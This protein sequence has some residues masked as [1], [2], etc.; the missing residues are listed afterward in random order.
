MPEPIVASR[1]RLLRFT[2]VGGYLL[3]VCAF[4]AFGAIWSEPLANLLAASGLVGGLLAHA[5]AWRRDRPNGVLAVLLLLGLALLLPCIPTRLRS[6][7][8]L[9]HFIA[10]GTTFSSSL[11]RH[12]ARAASLNFAVCM[13]LD[14]ND[15]GRRVRESCANLLQDLLRVTGGWDLNWGPTASGIDILVAVLALSAT[16]PG[17]NVLRHLAGALLTHVLGVAVA[18]L[19]FSLGLPPFAHLLSL[20]LT[21]ALYWSL[22]AGQ[23]LRPE[24]TEVPS[25]HPRWIP[26]ASSLSAVTAGLLIGACDFAQGNAASVSVPPVRVL[27]HAVGIDMRVPTRETLGPKSAGMFGLLPSFFASSGAHVD[28]GDV[29]SKQLSNYDLVVIANPRESFDPGVVVGI[30]AFVHQGGGLLLMGDHTGMESIR[31]PLNEIC[32]AW[33]IELNF[34][35]ARQL[36]GGWGSSLSTSRHPVIGSGLR[37]LELQIWTGASLDLGCDAT[38]IVC[39]MLGFSDPGDLRSAE[40]GYLGDLKY[41]RNERLGDLVLV[42]AAEP[43]L[44]RVLVFGDTSTWQNTA[45]TYSSRFAARCIAWLGGGACDRA[46]PAALDWLWSASIVLLLAAVLLAL[47]WPRSFL[48][49]GLSAGFLSVVG[50]MAA[51]N[52]VEALGSHIQ[53]GAVAGVPLEGRHALVDLS[54]STTVDLADAWSD[55]G[56]GALLLALMREGLMPAVR[57]PGVPVDLSQFE[58]VVIVNPTVDPDE[59]DLG[60][61][62]AWLR[63]GQGSL[64]VSSTQAQEA[65]PRLSQLHPSWSTDQILG[66]SRAESDFGPIRLFG[67]HAQSEDP[68]ASVIA[69]SVGGGGV[70]TRARHADGW[71]SV[72]ISDERLLLSG[73]LENQKSAVEDNIEFL[74]HL[75]RSML[76]D[77]DGVEAKR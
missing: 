4:P 67:A 37:S 15:T 12:F 17:A 33:G 57:L 24:A 64:L 36:P 3:A 41:Q 77:V 25:R 7:Y 61:L 2:A 59:T 76:Q 1:E 32:S 71:T 42:A 20:V 54:C 60:H 62:K 9:L 47:R 49:L 51:S 46:S 69:R 10:Q 55:R 8:V 56:I 29:S 63:A 44:G 70:V 52:S 30:Q 23:R 35:S 68:S 6:L 43:G 39:G 14:S 18:S 65:L 28:V 5:G 26:A 73:T 19:S 16:A 13:L 21:H 22:T 53:Q 48:L 58:L 50:Y 34:D 45:L 38:A 74:G 40:R 27:V 72:L 11:A 31:Q 66:P 75:I